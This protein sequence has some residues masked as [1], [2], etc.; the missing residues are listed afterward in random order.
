MCKSFIVQKA[1]SI[2]GCWVFSFLLFAAVFSYSQNPTETYTLSG[3]IYE[4][5]S[6]EMLLGVSV[7]VESLEV[8]SSTND[9]GFYSITLPKGI[10]TIT[11]S[12]LGYQ[13]QQK[14]LVLDNDLQMDFYL[15]P[16]AESLS[17]V[18]VSARVGERESEVTQMSKVSVTQEA[19]K[20]TPTLLGEK[21]VLKTL[22]LL[23]GI[24]GGNEGTAGLFVRGG[25]PDQNLIILDDATVYNSNHLFG[26]FSVFNG[27]ALK[28]VEAYKGGFPARFGGRLSSVI[29]IDTKDGNKEKL[30]GRFNVGL[31]SSSLVLE[32]PINK[33]KT[34]FLLSGRRTYVDVLSKPFLPDDVNAGYFFHDYTLKLHHV[35]NPKNKLYWST[36]TGEDRFFNREREENGDLY[37]AILGWGNITSTLRWNHQFNNKLFANTSLIYSR[38]KLRIQSDDTF[39]GER[40]IFRTSSGIND[41]SFKSDFNYYPNL[42]HSVRFGILGTVHRFT[43][44][45]VF[46]RDDFDNNQDTRQDINSFEGGVYVEDDWKVNPQFQVNAGF[47]WSYFRQDQ[48]TYQLPEP[49]LGLSYQWKPDLAL[50]ASYAN[51]NQYVHLLSTSGVGLP[52]DLWISST[53]QIKP[54]RGQQVSFGV[55]KD[56]KNDFA[57]SVEGY[58]KNME[59][60]IAYREGASFLIFDDLESGTELNWEDNITSGRAW[61]YGAEFLF[62][63]NTGR[64]TG[65][66]GYTLAWSKRQFDELNLGRVFNARYDRRHDISLVGFYKPNDKVTYS[67]NWVYTSGQNFTLPNVGGLSPNVGLPIGGAFDNLRGFNQFYLDT[68]SVARNNFNGEATHRLDIGI[69]W[70][71]KRSKSIRTWDLSIYNTYARANPFFYERNSSSID[72]DGDDISDIQRTNLIRYSLFRI[73]PSISYSLKF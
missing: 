61:S 21:D 33:G 15:L 44:Q 5:G 6:Q 12:Y 41:Y 26:F 65:W 36:Y 64:F 11:V 72:L 40:S 67:A 71:K 22:Q 20:N 66:L 30:E 16:K 55:A 34:S 17:E 50:K 14:E 69:Q 42:N 68:F 53:D 56:F 2:F 13:Y 32:G 38:Y 52:T 1:K 8:G 62:R 57:L 48:K 24:Q 37:R 4:S 60:I 43:P 35:F 63:K 45:Q 73:I 28:N 31:I 19:V 18:V 47:R 49:R 70:H 9:Y 39:E 54:Q 27:D 46:V 58:Y 51:M 29:K 3:Y 7:Y 59:D 23:P 10:H 25:T